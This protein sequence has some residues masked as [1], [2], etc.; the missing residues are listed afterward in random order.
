VEEERPSPNQE[1]EETQETPGRVITGD[2]REI[3][4]NPAPDGRPAHPSTEE[5]PEAD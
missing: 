1:D 5:V 4:G 3:G 2:P